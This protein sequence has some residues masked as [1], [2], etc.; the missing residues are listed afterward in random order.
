LRE[1]RPERVQPRNEAEPLECV[2][3][4]ATSAGENSTSCSCNQDSSLIWDLLRFCHDSRSRQRTFE[5]DPA[6]LETDMS[7]LLRKSG[8]WGWS[9]L[10]AKCD[11]PFFNARVLT[12]SDVVNDVQQANRSV[13]GC[14][15]SMPQVVFRRLVDAGGTLR[16]CAG[17]HGRSMVDRATCCVGSCSESTTRCFSLVV[18]ET[19]RTSNASSVFLLR[20]V[21][22]SDNEQVD[23][24]PCRCSHGWLETIRLLARFVTFQM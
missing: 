4:Y 17:L 22:L 8:G 5:V 7:I 20:V 10:G 2:R 13:L 9:C 19:V 18:Q 21:S 1:S 24:V 11:H 6:L 12:G 23:T 3:A 14:D 15:S 16:K